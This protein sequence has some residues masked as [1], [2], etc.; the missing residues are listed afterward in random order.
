[1]ACRFQSYSGAATPP[2][3]HLVAGTPAL[4]WPTTLLTPVRPVSHTNLGLSPS[5][6]FDTGC[7]PC[8]SRLRWVVWG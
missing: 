4:L 7:I 3:A 1:M 8:M 6:S 5:C 2:A